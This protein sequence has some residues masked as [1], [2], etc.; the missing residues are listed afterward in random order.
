MKLKKKIIIISVIV[1]ALAG[2]S[3]AFYRFWLSPRLDV[4][5]AV[6]EL[7]PDVGEPFPYFTDFSVTNDNTFTYNDG[8]ITA[9]FPK[10]FVQLEEPKYYDNRTEYERGADWI[11]TT[12]P[13]IQN[14]NSFSVPPKKCCENITKP[15]KEAV[16]SSFESFGLGRAETAYELYKAIYLLENDDYNFFDLDAAKTFLMAGYNKLNSE[17]LGETIYIYERDDIRAFVGVTF[18]EDSGRYTAM[19]RIFTADNPK[20]RTVIQMRTSSLD[21]IYGVINSVKTIK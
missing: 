11:W 10:D 3:E 6:Q 2:I 18:H 1:L 20:M 19:M 5:N 21:E 8:Y 17:V 15:E 9:E 14:K 16:Y 4:Y 13:F 7:I 12:D